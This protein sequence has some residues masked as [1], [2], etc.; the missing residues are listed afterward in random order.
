MESQIRD[1]DFVILICTIV[2]AEKSNIP[3]G[4]IGYEKNIISAEML[5][6]SDLRPKFI[7]VLRKGTFDIALPKYLGSKYAIDFR[8]DQNQHSALDELLRAIHYCP[9]NFY[10][11]SVTR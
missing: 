3:R 6:A 2:Y 8:E 1:S 10:E 4:G 7:S 9:V 11:P 5:Q